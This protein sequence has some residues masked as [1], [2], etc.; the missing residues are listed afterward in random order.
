MTRH[1]KK[2]KNK[3]KIVKCQFKKT[4]EHT[5]QVLNEHTQYIQI[6]RGMNWTDFLFNYN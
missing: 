5:R 6:T 3:K 4:G 1:A 2:L